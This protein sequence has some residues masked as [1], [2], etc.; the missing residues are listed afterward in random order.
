MPIGTVAWFSAARGNGFL[1]QPG[2]DEDVFV[3]I[4]DV[5]QAGLSTLSPGQRVSFEVGANQKNGGRPKAVN[6]TLAPTEG[7]T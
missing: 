2:S 3:H 1:A 7:E 4:P 5:Q 6:L